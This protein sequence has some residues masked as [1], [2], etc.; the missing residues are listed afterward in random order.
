MSDLSANGVCVAGEGVARPRPRLLWGD[1]RSMLC[2]IVGH[3]WWN[4][5]RESD[6]DHPKSIH[7]K[8][9]DIRRVLPDWEEH[10]KNLPMQAGG[11][12]SLSGEFVIYRE[13]MD[14]AG[15]AL[16]TLAP[17]IHTE[18]DDRAK[19]EYRKLY[20]LVRSA[21]ERMGDGPPEAVKATDPTAA[22]VQ[23]AGTPNPV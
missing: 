9:Q 4:L 13:L 2:D 5:E 22:G 15:E 17:L 18:R 7:C 12:V 21:H 23:T 3:L 19:A 10:V 14:G 6:Q 20:S 1:P 16:E 8:A 11:A